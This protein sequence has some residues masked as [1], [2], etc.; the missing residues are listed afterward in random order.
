MAR[1]LKYSIFILNILKLI[2]MGVGGA[3]VWHVIQNFSL[4]GT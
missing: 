4:F 1:L 2:A 3:A